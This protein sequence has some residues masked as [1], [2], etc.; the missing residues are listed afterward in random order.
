MEQLR[1]LVLGAGGG[2]RTA[3][4]VLERAWSA[5]TPDPGRCPLAFLDDRLAGQVV[6]GYRV[7]GAAAEALRWACPPAGERPACVVAFGTG[8]LPQRRAAF[9]RLA[10]AGAAFCTAIDP[11]AVI[12]RTARVGRGAVIAAQCVV[13]PNAVVGDNGFL[14]VATTVDHDVVLGDHVYCSPG[15]N[16]AGGVVIEDEALLGTNATVLPA[17]RIGR[18]AVVGAGAVVRHDVPPG[19]TVV[20]NPATVLRLCPSGG[21]T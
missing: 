10:E 20:G 19:A 3:A 4:A 9:E 6:N 17:V 7:L 14:C 21:L 15:V 16:L 5:R 1:Y 2:G 18:G 8:F 12:D 13:H 11:S